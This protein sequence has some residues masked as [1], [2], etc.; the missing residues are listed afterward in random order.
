MEPEL[1]FLPPEGE[2]EGVRRAVLALLSPD[3]WLLAPGADGWQFPALPVSPGQSASAAA[4]RLLKGTVPAFVCAFRCRAG[5]EPFLGA[6]L[7]ARLPEG[8]AVPGTAAFPVL[9]EALSWPKATRALF[10]RAQWHLNAQHSRGEVWDVYDASR[11]RT[12]ALCRRGEPLPPGGYH[13]VVHAWLRMPDGSFLLTR[14]APGKGYALLWECTGG[15]AQAGEDSLAAV[16][17][18]IREET[19]LEA[20]PECGRL[21]H[22]IRQEGHL[23]DLWCFQQDFDL[24]RVRLQP[25]ETCGARTASLAEVYRMYTS[26]QLVPYDYFE[27]FFPAFF[28]LEKEK[29]DEA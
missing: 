25:G 6:L 4:A 14:R 19:G 21:L 24:A 18:E 7:F 27:S 15:A 11:R 16:L 13:L 17:R 12:G 23:L 22:T 8:C 1:T 29:T 20:R 28:P 9:P 26:G 3:G 2:P 10:Q 5:V